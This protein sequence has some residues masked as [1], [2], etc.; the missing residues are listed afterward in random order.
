[1]PTISVDVDVELDDFDDSDLIEE[2]RAR[3]YFVSDDA[4]DTPDVEGIVHELYVARCME[5]TNIDSILNKLF[6]TVLN[7]RI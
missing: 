5:D 4:I 2:L 6:E 1:M 7:K 3:S